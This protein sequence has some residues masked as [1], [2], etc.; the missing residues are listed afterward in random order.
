[1][2]SF[3]SRLRERKLAQWALAYLAGAWLIFEATEVLAGPWNLSPTFQRGVHLLLG[4][5]FIIMLVLA[6]YH[7]EKGRQHVSGPELLIIAALLAVAGFIV[8]VVAPTEEASDRSLST[9]LTEPERL[10]PAVAVLPFDNISPNPED[11]Y[12]ADGMQEE[13]ITQLQKVSGIAVISRTSTMRYRENPPPVREIATQLGVDFVLEGSARKAGERVRLTVQLIDAGRD[14]HLWADEYDRDL[15]AGD[16]FEIQSDLALR[17]TGAL[18]GELSPEEKAR[19]E[20]P[21]TLN[22]EAHDEYF[23]GRYEWNKRTPEGF[24]AAIQHFQRATELDSTFA[25]AYAGLA[26]TYVLLPIYIEDV[27]SRA[28]YREAES[29]A[30]RALSLDATLA[31]A[32]VPLGGVR[33]WAHYD[34]IGA[35]TRFL[36]AIE[37]SPA[38]A[39]AHHWYSLALSVLG[40]HEEALAEARRALQL[41]P[42]SVV[43]NQNLAQ[44]LRWAGDYEAA[45]SQF[46][47]T[48]ELSP[49]FP[50]TF[51]W[52]AESLLWARRFDDARHPLGRFFELTGG[53]P[54]TASRLV[55][56][57]VEYDRSGSPAPIPPDIEAAAGDRPGRLFQIY[58]LAGQREKTLE[59]LERAYERRRSGILVLKDPA[60]DFLRDDPRFIALM[61]NINLSP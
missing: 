26:D 60:Y 36:Q 1:M 33:M 47:R 11:A 38:Y 18:T 40:R 51:F 17:I 3:L 23:R 52:M 25:H 28:L 9:G 46:E 58:A 10:L 13:I 19:I 39:T 56:L 8:T 37:L 30:Q 7:G 44:N 5:G 61:R 50:P 53:A 16:L 15:T 2:N 22:L 29:A 24:S 41:D 31:E 35:E 4:I 32:H 55:D 45:I 6:W 20:T 34:W 27:D 42:L 48:L 54:E 49:E 57:V 59:W 21:P 14:E 43:I 12:F